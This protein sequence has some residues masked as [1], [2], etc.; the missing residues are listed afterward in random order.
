MTQIVFIVL[1]LLKNSLTFCGTGP[2]REINIGAESF[3]VHL[4][5]IARISPLFGLKFGK[6]ISWLLCPVKKRIHLF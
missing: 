4:M 5:G 3:S 2:Q 1:F 6:P